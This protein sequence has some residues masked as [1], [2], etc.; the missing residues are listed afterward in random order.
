MDAYRVPHLTRHGNT[1]VKPVLGLEQGGLGF[2]KHEGLVNGLLSLMGVVMY[3]HE[4]GIQYLS[5]DALMFIGGW[6]T[7]SVMVNFADLFN[8]SLWNSRAMGSQSLP[9]PLIVRSDYATHRIAAQTVFEIGAEKANRVD[10]ITDPSVCWFWRSLRPAAALSLVV[11][12]VRPVGVYGAIHPRIENDLRSPGL[13]QDYWSMKTPLPAVYDL[14]SNFSHPCV[15]VRHAFYMCVMA[16]DVTEPEEASILERRVTPWENVP[17]ALGGYEAV[18]RAGLEGYKV[19]GAVLDLEIARG[20]SFFIGDGGFSTFTNA[21]I[22]S[23]SCDGTQCNIRYTHNHIRE[24]R[25]PLDF[26]V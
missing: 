18:R 24:T 12:K 17:L 11:E 2:S 9:L 7:T 4:H 10:K 14:I 6:D 23:R 20:A 22:T 15:S 3:A 21:I 8:V 26:P 1:E 16:S 19:Q 25:L 5:D 13:A